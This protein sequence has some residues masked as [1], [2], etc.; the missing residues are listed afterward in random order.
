M[1]TD[2]T[3]RVL[4][5]VHF[6]EEMYERVAEKLREEIEDKEYYATKSLDIDNVDGVGTLVI[7]TLNAM[8]YR[9]KVVYYYGGP[10]GGEIK[11]VVP[12]WWECFT[13]QLND[14]GDFVDA[15]N[16]FQFSKVRE[17]LKEV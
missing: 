8:I 13:Y 16:D 17:L 7:L 1:S 10:E 14:E 12:I 2:T 9:S 15:T 3:C 6:T 5:E 11:D 4:G